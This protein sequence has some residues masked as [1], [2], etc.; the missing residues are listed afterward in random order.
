M[1]SPDRSF[2]AYATTEL[3]DHGAHGS[4]RHRVFDLATSA[5]LADR[6]HRWSTPAARATRC[7]FEDKFNGAIDRLGAI[8]L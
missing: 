8:A 1:L 6:L 3:E 7:W 5:L 4:D 2:A